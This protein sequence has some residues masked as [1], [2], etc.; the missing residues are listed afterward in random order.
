MTGLAG[1]GGVG[2][3]PGPGVLLDGVVVGLRVQPEAPVLVV[4]VAV[5][6]WVGAPRVPGVALIQHLDYIQHG[7]E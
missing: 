7:D 1:C 2:A 4:W 5:D 3:A 6:G